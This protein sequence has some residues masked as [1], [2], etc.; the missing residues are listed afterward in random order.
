MSGAQA[1]AG[2]L[3]GCVTVVAEVDNISTKYTTFQKFKLTKI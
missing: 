1:K 2:Y 3:L